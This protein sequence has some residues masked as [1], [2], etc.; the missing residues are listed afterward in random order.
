VVVE[1][2]VTWN[3]FP[4][5]LLRRFG[6]ERALQ[7]ADC[8]WPIEYFGNPP[9]DPDNPAGTKLD[10]FYRPQEEY[11]EWHVERDADTNKIRRITFTSEP[12]E[13]WQALFGPIPGGNGTPD[14]AF[15]G[16]RD[17][18]LGLYRDLVSEDVQLE[19]LV[20]PADIKDPR[21]GTL[22][23]KG[24]YY[25]YNKWNTTHGIAHLNSP[26][27]SLFAEIQL[28]ADATVPRIDREG[29]LL[30]EPDA[31]ICYAGYG[32]PN[33]NSDPTIGAAVNALAR[34]G[35]WVTLKNPVGLYMDHIDLSGWR[36]P[37]GSDIT[38]FIRVV[39]GSLGMIERMV[40]EAPPGHTLCVGDLMIAGE[41][42]RYGGQVAE[43]ITVKLTGLANI[44][45]TPVHT[46][47]VGITGRGEID[48]ANARIVDRLRLTDPS[49]PGTV[50]AF[51]HEG[52]AP[53]EAAPATAA[54]KRRRAS[55]VAAD[56]RTRHPFRAR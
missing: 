14:T 17:V 10:V 33:R 9:R 41:L 37:D 1:Q 29:R 8:L 32:G 26:P 39:R 56:Q 35:A 50:E 45:P 7:L 42:V 38:Q 2:A 22:A 48:P 25:L 36:A 40:V 52:T 55:A 28:G 19:D 18:L 49:R 47:P 16:D 20:A 30:V 51:L 54:A 27:N 24:Q 15:P 11:C 13:Y 3:A 23:L 34:L 21:Q 53:G 31:L 43:C 5:E 6:R 46:P 4:K 12:P 44:P